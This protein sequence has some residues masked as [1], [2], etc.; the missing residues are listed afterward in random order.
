MINNIFNQLSIGMD[1]L[2]IFATCIYIAYILSEMFSLQSPPQYPSNGRD[3]VFGFSRIAN[4]GRELFAAEP[5][6]RSLVGQ[7]V[8]LR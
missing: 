6:K 5:T 1:I 7:N 2:A 8:S 3:G 4:L